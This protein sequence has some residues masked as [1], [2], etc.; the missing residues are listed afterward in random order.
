MHLATI[1]RRVCSTRW[2]LP[3]FT[4][5]L[6]VALGGAQWKGGDRQT[7]LTSM[8]L[9]AVVAAA[10][11]FGGRSETIRMIRGDGRDERWTRIDL[12]ATALAGLTAITAIIVACGWEWAHG[13]DGTPFVQLGAIS[14]VA[15]IVALV[16]LG[17]RS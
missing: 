12:A 13:R 11:L 9:F 2:F 5:V 1:S 4:V 16:V 17:K 10:L 8:A 14:G 15:Y 6:G 7:G 3:A